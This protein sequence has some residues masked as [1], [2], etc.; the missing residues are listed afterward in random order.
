M[1]KILILIFVTILFIILSSNYLF[2]E[3]FVT[4]KRKKFHGCLE[5]QSVLNPGNSLNALS[6]G[7]CID[8]DGGNYNNEDDDDS[9]FVNSNKK[10]LL[11]YKRLTGKESYNSEEKSWC[12]IPI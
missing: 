1:V 2:Y 9:N 11:P 7:W 10:C 12:K 5:G 6:K 8:G 3:D 4:S